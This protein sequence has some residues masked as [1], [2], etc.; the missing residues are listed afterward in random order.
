MNPSLITYELMVKNYSQFQQNS[1]NNYT[2]ALTE[3]ADPIFIWPRT[4][5]AH[6]DDTS[7]FSLPLNER[8]LAAIQIV[9]FQILTNTTTDGVKP[10]YITLEDPSLRTPH[11]IVGSGGRTLRNVWAALDSSSSFQKTYG[12]LS[13]IV[14]VGKEF[15]LRNINIRLYD[16]DQEPFSLHDQLNWVDTSNPKAFHA[17]LTVKVFYSNKK[18]P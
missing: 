11:R 3:D 15:L 18:Q 13:H 2:G 12:S 10:E 4:G 17:L 8:N 6:T 9:S 16:A 1:P 14:P 7:Q 5:S